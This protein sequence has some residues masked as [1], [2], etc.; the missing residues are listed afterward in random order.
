[1]MKGIC[2]EVLSLCY[3]FKLETQQNFQIDAIHSNLVL[4][5]ILEGME[6]AVLEAKTTRSQLL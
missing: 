3:C 6:S 1:M 5:I 2:G 4:Q